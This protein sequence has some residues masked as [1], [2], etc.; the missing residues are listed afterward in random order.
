M[1]L[2]DSE[3]DLVRLHLVR[4]RYIVARAAAS[5]GISIKCLYNRI[6]D[7]GWSLKQMRK[8]MRERPIPYPI[9]EPRDLS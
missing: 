6:S 5:L 3:R 7:Y 4:S 9:G 8:E 2:K 1:T